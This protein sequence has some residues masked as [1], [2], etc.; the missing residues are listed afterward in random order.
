MRHAVGQINGTAW[1]MD[2]CTSKPNNCLMKAKDF[3]RSRSDTCAE[4][5]NFVESGEMDEVKHIHNFFYIAS[6]YSEKQLNNIEII[7]YF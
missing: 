2:P 4:T 3:C 5:T 6:I 7:F 1:L